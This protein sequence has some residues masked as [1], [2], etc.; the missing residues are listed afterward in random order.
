MIRLTDSGVVFNKEAHTYHLEG[1]ELSG[2]TSVIQRQLFPNE[3]DEVPEEMIQAAAEYGNAVHES[4]EL[5]DR[6]WVNDGTVEVADYIQ[7]THSNQLVHEASEYLVTD[8][9][10][11]ASSIDK[12]YR[13]N[14]DT[15]TLADIKTYGTLTPEKMER[16]KWQLSIYAYLFT[17]QNP[18]AKID[19]LLVIRLRSKGKD[20]I[21]EI[22]EVE[23][24]PAN[25]C[26]ALLEADLNGEA[27]N[28][29]YSIPADIKA[30]EMTIRELI[31]TKQQVDD[32]LKRIKADILMRMEATNAKLW[33][34]DSM[35]ITRKLPTQRESFD[36]ARYKADNPDL[37]LSDYMKVSN[38][39]G[40]VL[41]TI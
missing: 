31:Q 1:K 10:H 26:K 37:N 27:F 2:I 18:G 8:T 21:N 35:R 25:I 22:I 5:F 9:K 28:N 11:Y 33:E 12:V 3:Y 24:I 30:Q 41:I 17:L 32:E 6:E 39:S 29:P 19:R 40:S 23:R 20:H 13:I 14:K 4:C 36:L 34:T 15:F 38:V 16:A 7:L